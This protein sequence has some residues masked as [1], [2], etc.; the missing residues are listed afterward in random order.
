MEDLERQNLIAK[1][2]ELGWFKII[3]SYKMFLTGK[4]KSKSKKK[5]TKSC[6]DNFTIDGFMSDRAN[7]FKFTKS[8]R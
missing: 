6:D 7:E 3:K 8:I 2:C 4:P 1:G 5:V